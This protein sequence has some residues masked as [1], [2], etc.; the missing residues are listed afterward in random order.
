MKKEV[1]SFLVAFAAWAYGLDRQLF[2]PKDIVQRLRISSGG[3]RFCSDQGE[4]LIDTSITYT[5]APEYQ[6]SPAI[7]FDGVNYF[8]VWAD[9]RNGNSDIYGARVTVE[10]VVLDPAGIPISTA[11]ERQRSPAVAFDGTNYF[12]VWEDMRNA[13]DTADIYGAR[14]TPAGILLDTS[15]IPIAVARNWQFNPAIAFDG[16]N[17]LVVWN[18]GRN[19]SYYVTD[20]YGARVTPAGEVLDSAGIVI[21]VAEDNQRDPAIAFD[22]TNFL[23]VWGDGRNNVQYYDIYG[24]RV[25]PAGEVLDS[26]GIRISNA[27]RDEFK[28]AVV[29]DGM[30]YF[31]VWS[32]CRNGSYYDI[33]GC[34]VSPSGEVLEPS[35]IAISRAPNDQFSPAVAFDGNNIF[36][37][38]ED[39]RSN[40]DYPDIYG[41][42]VTRKGIVLDTWGIAVSIA[43]ERQESPAITFGGM[44]CLVVWSDKRSGVFEYDIFGTMVTKEGLIVNPTGIPMATAAHPQ[45]T[46]VVGFD[47]VNYLVIWADERK[48]NSDIYGA[49]VTPQGVV[50]DPEGFSISAAVEDQRDPAVAFDGENYLVVWTDYRNG[51]YNS[52]IYGAR[53]VP[54]GVVLDPEGFSI[55][56]AVEDQRDPAVAF[57]GENYLVVWTDYRNGLYNSDIY[58]ARVA[59]QGVV[60]DTSPITISA[61]SSGQALPA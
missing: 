4:F 27:E 30:N 10:G 29:F 17:Y 20:I 15:G 16:L 38:W 56:A 60:L 48:G 14:V 8:V 51:L 36:V 40:N 5:C 26:G 25:T 41:C 54:Q 13:P 31:V 49:R 43:P 37:M 12:V 58:G 39:G 22:G 3:E 35:G 2:Y 42:R 50:L 28:P 19:G 52:D 32:D 7:A 6:H 53:V 57:D 47:G 59:P 23:I 44:N 55:S 21:A 18:D 46:P 45:A 1:V 61:A 9:E 34:R 33:Y 11:P 24:A